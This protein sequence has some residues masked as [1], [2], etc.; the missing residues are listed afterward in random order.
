M[1]AVK[2]KRVDK[3]LKTGSVIHWSEHAGGQVP[4]T[5]GDCGVKRPVNV[6]TVNRKNFTGLCRAS[7]KAQLSTFLPKKPT[8]TDYSRQPRGGNA[9]K[10][11]IEHHRSNARIDWDDKTDHHVA[12]YCANGDECVTPGE[13]VQVNQANIT[14]EGWTGRCPACIERDGLPLKLKGR[15]E[16]KSGAVADFDDRDETRK[17]AKIT[18]PGGIHPRYILLEAISNIIRSDG[19]G[20][21][22]SCGLSTRKRP[23]EDETLRPSNSIIHWSESN[24]DSVPV[25]CGYCHLNRNASV[26][27]IFDR[28]RDGR[29][30]SGLCQT[31]SISDLQMFYLSASNGQEN[32]RAV[33]RPAD[34]PEDKEA[35]LE[36]LRSRFESVILTLAAELPVHK[37]NRPAILSEYQKRGELLTNVSSITKRV[38]LLYGDGVSVADAVASVLEKNR[39]NNS[40]N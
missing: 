37:I 1:Q 39:E 24:K 14:Y 36:Q 31:H 2:A 15:H 40:G 9:K 11:G 29:G 22:S 32:G 33:G 19:S 21:C 38:E 25:T 20:L 30:Y 10:T 6:G 13:K 5:C 4:V 16:F 26:K 34:R 12:I 23:L 3:R 17:R 18:C 27:S 7:F 35:E 8:T 28:Q